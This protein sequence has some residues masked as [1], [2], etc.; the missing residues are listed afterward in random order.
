MNIEYKLADVTESF[1][2][3]FEANRNILLAENNE[4]LNSIRREAVTSLAKLKIPGKK[5]ENYKYTA[6]GDLLFEEMNHVFSPKKIEFNIEDI[7]SCDIPEIDTQ[8]ILVLNGFFL[9]QGE[10]ITKLENGVIIG[11]L[12]AAMKSYPDL[13]YKHFAQYSDYKN[14]PI[15]ALNTAFAQDGVF[16]YV[17]KNVK[18]EKSIQII[19]LLLSE[20]DQMVQHRNLFILEE[21]AEANVVI[22]DHSL[23]IQK[24]ITNSVTEVFADKNSNFNITRVQ[25]EH[26]KSVQ[27]TN[28][29]IQ[30]EQDSTVTSNTISLHGGVIRNNIK[31]NLNGENCENNSLGLFLADKEQHIDNSIYINHLKPNCTSN[32]LYKGILDENARGAFAGRIHVWPDAQK[33]MA[34]QKNNNILLSDDAKM[35]SKP[36]LEIYADD[37]K[38]SHGATVGQLDEEALF[39]MRSRGINERESRLLLMYA[40]AHEV[41][42]EIKLPAL[43]ERIDELVE[44]RLRGELSRCNNCKMNC[45]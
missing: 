6:I 15:A 24:F 44:K 34:Y 7:F 21:G 38:C 3:L 8:A 5:S 16:L 22:C 36:Q 26:D 19:H 13:V 40:F 29:F 17:P 25:N 12:R 32:Q 45:R 37:V 14:D 23:S 11:S 35:N 39:Y 2:S 28:S 18:H 42:S 27:I 33:T 31:V 4:H 20:E 9:N 30:Q 10:E 1:V 43:R 41:I